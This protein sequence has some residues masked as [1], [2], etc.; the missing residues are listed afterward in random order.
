M[1]VKR[2]LEVMKE[3]K[4]ANERHLQEWRDRMGRNFYFTFGSDPEYPFGRDD[5]VRITCRDAGTACNL[6]N[7]LYPKRP[8]SDA[9]NCAFMYDQSAWDRDVKQWYEGR[10]PIESVTVETGGW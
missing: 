6:F 2:E 9:M 10:E 1:D 5:Y 3:V 8:G 7:A 4:E